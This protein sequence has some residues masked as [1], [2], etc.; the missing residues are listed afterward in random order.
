MDETKRDKIHL[1]NSN[2]PEILRKHIDTLNLLLQ[3]KNAELTA[4][5][6]S[7]KKIVTANQAIENEFRDFVDKI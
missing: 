4:K 2:D 5:D 6:E 7:L 3:S 1:Q